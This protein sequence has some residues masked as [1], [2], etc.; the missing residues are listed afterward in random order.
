MPKNLGRHVL[1]CLL[2][3]L[4][5]PLGAEPLQLFPGDLFP[6]LSL[7]APDRPAD[8]DY[9]TLRRDH[10]TPSEIEAELLLVELFNVHC[11]HCQH[12]APVYNE[13][14]RMIESRSATRG[15]IKLLG[16]AAGNRPE[17]VEAFRREYQVEFPLLA[18]PS[19]SVWQ[20]IGGTVTPLSLYVRQTRPGQPG[21]V[22]G[23]K[24]GLNDDYASLYGHLIQLAESDAEQ[25]RQAGLAAAAE[26]QARR[27]APIL[28]PEE[29][30][31]RVRDASTRFGLLMD[32]AEVPLASGRQVYTAWLRSDA[33]NRRLFAEVVGRSAVC[34]LCHDVHF[35]YLFD[36]SG[37]IVAF[38]PLQL[39]KGYQG[40]NAA[41]SPAEVE[42][43]RQ[44]IL[45]RYL[46]MPQPFDPRVDAISSATMT[47]AIIFDSLTRGDA[48]LQELRR[49][50]LL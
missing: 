22:A 29:L 6:E 50:G 8:R 15:L 4:A 43:T 44:K 14:F 23:V 12:Q 24:Q 31:Y 33:Q 30:E 18:D 36:R 49:Q 19:F 46:S 20:R 13:L 1:L 47:S 9:L 34:D 25:L 28:P 42:R 37:Q 7:P 27:L 3:L 45:G 17:E 21:V 48:L 5:A 40:R 38:E 35:I 2:W 32:F 26:R 16:I 10:F 11:P 39:T 41:W